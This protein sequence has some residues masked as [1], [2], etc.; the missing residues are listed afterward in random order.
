M[1]CGVWRSRK[2]RGERGGG[3]LLISFAILRGGA[4]SIMQLRVGRPWHSST[5]RSTLLLLW[6]S[7]VSSLLFHPRGRRGDAFVLSPV[8]SRPSVEDAATETSSYNTAV[9]PP[10]D[11]T[12]A[13]SFYSSTQIPF[14][15]QPLTST[16]FFSDTSFHTLFHSKSYFVHWPVSNKQQ[17]QRNNNPLPK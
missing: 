17:S 14:Y 9:Q 10:M 1:D 13:I 12:T 3:G 15:N 4:S 5:T 7:S 8:L 16:A 11:L 2:K 6:Q